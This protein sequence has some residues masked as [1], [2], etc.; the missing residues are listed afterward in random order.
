MRFLEDRGYDLEAARHTPK[1][2]RDIVLKTGPHLGEFNQGISLSE[3][4]EAVETT[5]ALCILGK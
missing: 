4:I 3:L 2:E 5:T 1:G